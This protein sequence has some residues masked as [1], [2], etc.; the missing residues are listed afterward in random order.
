MACKARAGVSWPWRRTP[1]RL[2]PLAPRL[3]PAPE[4]LDWRPAAPDHETVLAMPVVHEQGGSRRSSRRTATRL[5]VAAGVTA[6]L[7]VGGRSAGGSQRGHC[8]RHDH[9]RRCRGYLVNVLA[10]TPV[11]DLEPRQGRARLRDRR[12]ADSPDPARWQVNHA[13]GGA[14]RGVPNL[15]L[16]AFE[17]P[18]SHHGS[19]RRSHG[20]R[21]SCGHHGYRAHDARAW[22]DRSLP[23]QDSLRDCDVR[24]HQRWRAPRHP[25]ARHLPPEKE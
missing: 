22:G 13:N 8:C 12:Q 14:Q 9:P 2:T 6:V 7:A 17:P 23:E 1:S 24:R 18:W 4:W 15:F 10:G 3:L 19:P 21:E 11:Q 16:R 25:L 20:L 5:T